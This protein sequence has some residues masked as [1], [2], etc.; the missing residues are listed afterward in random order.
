V[1]ALLIGIAL[2]PHAANF[3]KPLDYAN[4]SQS[5]LNST[6]LYFTRLVLS[7]Q[8]VLAGV[9][10][11]SRYL[12]TEWKALVLFL[13]LVMVFMW[14]SSGLLIWVMVPHI[15]FLQALAVGVGNTGLPPMESHRKL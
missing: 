5:D 6:T 11:P 8:L 15:S 2:S 12:R 13:G 14:L 9:Q 4:G 3:I 1:I 10:L 7:V